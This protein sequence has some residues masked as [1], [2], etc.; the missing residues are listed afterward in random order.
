MLVCCGHTFCKGCI[1]Q[2]LSSNPACPTCRKRPKLTGNGVARFD[3]ALMPNVTVDQILDELTVH[4]RHGVMQVEGG[5]WLSDPSGCGAV[6][7]IEAVEAHEAECQHA[8]VV[9]TYAHL[10]CGWTGK[11]AD[12]GAHLEG[13]VWQHGV[14]VHF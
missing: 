11:R 5:Q 4:C 1:V 8:R 12:Q 3:K 9:C 2:T 7:A 6:L 13:C 14:D 10:G